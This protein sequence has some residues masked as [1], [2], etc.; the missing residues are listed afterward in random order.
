MSEYI[1]DPE[2]LAELEGKKKKPA[3][4][5]YVT[6]PK[7]LA[8]L[9]KP[10]EKETAMQTLGRSTASLADTLTNTATGLVDLPARAAIR[11][12]Q[13]SIGGKSLDEAERIAQQYGTFPKDTFGRAFGV[14]GTPGYENAPLR[15][16]GTMAGQ[17]IG[18][19]IIQPV[20]QATGLP[21][22]YV[23]DVAGIAS[24]GLGPAVPK[25]AGSAIRGAKNVAAPVME[26]GK[27][28]AGV[29]T[30]TTAKPGV[31]PKVWQTESSRIPASNEYF[32]ASTQEQ[33][34]Q[35]L[36]TTDEFNKTKTPWTEQQKELLQ[37]TKGN[38]PVVGQVARAAGEQFM[39]PLTGWKGWLPEVAAGAAGGLVGGPGGAALGAGLALG[40]K[41]YTA[42][43]GAKQINAMN[44]LGGLK[45]TPQ[46]AAEQAALQS[47]APHP[48]AGPVMPPA[49][50]QPAPMPAPTSTALT[51]QGP[52]QQ[53]PPST[54]PMGG[55]Q[56][57]VNIE[58]QSFQLPNQIN[59]ANSQAARPQQT[60]AQ[61]SQ[62]LAAQK[63]SQVQNQAPVAGPVAPTQLP[64]APPAPPAAPAPVVQ[65]QPKPPAPAPQAATLTG[66]ERGQ[67][68]KDWVAGTRTAPSNPLLTDEKAYGA[69]NL[70]RRQAKDLIKAGINEIPV[71]QGA[72][73][74]Q[75]IEAMH[76]YIS[77]NKPEMFKSKKTK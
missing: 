35:G 19:N 68:I 48:V 57:N 1:T 47:G 52:G 20:A 3:S 4:K 43:Q 14:T 33:W 50:P 29:A 73:E 2:L 65:P 10:P 58:G 25:V 53:L 36:I 31:Q 28:A 37:K 26:F 41:A 42:V 32:P 23:G 27:G 60:P 18:E 51:V 15:S 62:Q 61:Y 70:A 72:N 16:L 46:T 6:D 63:L 74:K 55:P 67:M 49:R 44:Q 66:A 69:S 13:G 75:V 40:K 5:G 30:G 24:M 8:E 38:V 34:R 39:E 56:R 76:G 64:P 77:K 9:N 59:T 17:A 11:A 21:E 54:I 45:F 71:I 22:S 7:L 12:Y